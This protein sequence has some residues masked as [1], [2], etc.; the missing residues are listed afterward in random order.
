MGPRKFYSDFRE[1]RC[2]ATDTEAQK[3]SQREA[4]EN[5][6]F[7]GGSKMQTI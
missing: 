4:A 6:F 3:L 1:P 5:Y 2:A 7:L